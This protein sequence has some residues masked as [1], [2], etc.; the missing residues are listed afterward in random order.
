MIRKKHVCDVS[1][2]VCT[3]AARGLLAVSVV[4]KIGGKLMRVNDLEIEVAKRFS[5]SGHGFSI[6]LI[7]VENCTVEIE[8]GFPIPEFECMGKRETVFAA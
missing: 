3:F 1:T 5:D 8:S 7:N 2:S 6:P 4:G